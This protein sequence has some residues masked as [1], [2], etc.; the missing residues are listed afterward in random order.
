[1]SAAGGATVPE[2]VR[3]RGNVV[4]YTW[5]VQV[6]RAREE[7]AYVLLKAWSEENLLCAVHD[8]T[9]ALV[10]FQC[11]ALDWARADLEAE[12]AKVARLRNALESV[13]WSGWTP[14][15][16]VA[17]PSCEAPGQ[18]ATHTS[19]CPLAAVLRDTAPEGSEP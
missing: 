13:E 14:G 15:C 1:M 16:M 9:G 3:E 8:Y 6:L 5:I 10:G 4:S 7:R 2:T 11:K 19:D 17:C 12:R 18:R